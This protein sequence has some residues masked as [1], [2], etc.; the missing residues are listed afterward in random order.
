MYYK[1]WSSTV[2]GSLWPKF[3]VALK[4]GVAMKPEECRDFRELELGLQL[5]SEEGGKGKKK[6]PPSF[7]PI[8]PAEEFYPE[9]Q[10]FGEKKPTVH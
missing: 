7:P 6:K 2:F 1:T 10:W 5:A 9:P 8:F 4:G 3:S